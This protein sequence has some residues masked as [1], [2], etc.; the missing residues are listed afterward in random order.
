MRLSANINNQF[1]LRRFSGSIGGDFIRPAENEMSWSTNCPVRLRMEAAEPGNRP[2]ILVQTMMRNCV[3]RFGDNTAMVSYERDRS[4]TY[5]DYLRSVE[6]VARGFKSLGLERFG[7]VGIMGHNSPEWYLSSVGA[8][9]AGGLSCGIYTTNS[10]STVAHICHES[11]LELLVVENFSLLERLMEGGSSINEKYPE[12][13]KVI[14]VDT[15][16]KGSKKYGGDQVLSWDELLNTGQD[17]DLHRLEEEQAVND[18]C[19]LIYTSGTTGPPK[20][21]M[22]SHDNIT[23]TAKVA[24][25]HYDWNL[26]SEV[27]LSYLPLSHV[28]AQLVDIYMLMCIGGRAHFSDREALKGTLVDNLK[29]VRPTRFLAVPRVWEKIQEKMQAAAKQNGF[30]KK[31]LGNWAKAAATRHHSEIRAGKRRFGDGGGFH[32]R[33]AKKLIFGRI[34]EALGLDR[35][36]SVYSSAA[37]LSVPTFE[38]FQ[39]LD[40]ILIELLGC[41]ETSG[42]QFTN[43]PHDL[44]PGT[45]GKSYDGVINDIRRGEIITRSRNVFMG[46]A[47]DETATRSSFTEDGWFKSGDL[48]SFD[49]DGFLILNGRLKELL[50]TSGGEN[51][52]PRPIEEAVLNELSPL[53]SQAVVIGDKRK[54]LSV[55]ITLRTETAPDGNPTDLLEKSASDWCNV[56]VN[57]GS[58]VKTITDFRSGPHSSLFQAEIQKAIERANAFAISN[59]AKVQKFLILPRDLSIS[60]GELGPTLKLKRHFI[61]QKYESDINRL[62]E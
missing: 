61:H 42:P 12:L 15:S 40:L 13:K 47:N 57:D 50:I 9:F 43:L 45:N 27:I 4:W 60:G 30:V 52:A 37:P 58:E 20:A 19:M 3:Q 51:V 17:V 11:P 5:G 29:S 56:L 38:Y 1:A 55:L 48:A 28:A 49:P 33:M 34:H 59:A 62:Y 25:E 53:L 39:S 10:P 44:R 8:I 54:F 35:A 23:W 21:A 14:V 22:L 2:P 16:D 6:S 46:Y 18:A 31:S 24:M 7:G 36:L 41:S 32:Y 26:G